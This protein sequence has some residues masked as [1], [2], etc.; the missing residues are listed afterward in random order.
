MKATIAAQS[1]ASIRFKD[2]LEVC[3]M[4]FT[5][6]QS[7]RLAGV[8]VAMVVATLAA[9]ACEMVLRPTSVVDRVELTPV[10]VSVPAN[11][12]VDFTAV[13]FSAS[14]DTVDVDVAWSATGGTV[15]PVATND[16]GRHVG[17]FTNGTCGDYQVSATV[18][19]SGKSGSSNVTVTCEP[20][21]PPPPP[22]PPRPP[23]PPP[24]PPRPRPPPPSSRSYPCGKYFIQE[25]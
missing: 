5:F 21:P 16:R 10:A 25:A 4:P 23:P 7:R 18:Q 12:T 1:S 15:T 24:P 11:Q 3:A 9:V 19:P 17:Q 8:S 13:A 14:N 2:A 22:P 20:P 6:Q